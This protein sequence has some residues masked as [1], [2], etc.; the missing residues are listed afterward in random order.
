MRSVYP[1]PIV[2]AVLDGLHALDVLE[3]IDY[4]PESIQR[5]AP[6]RI[7]CFCPVHRETEF[8]SLEVDEAAKSFRCVEPGCA[9]HEGGDLIQL[10]A[11]ARGIDYDQALRVL[12][13][14]FV[15][16]V[17]LP[18]DAEEL[19]R[20]LDEA[21]SYL[22]KLEAGAE[23]PDGLGE[24]VLALLGGALERQRSHRR[25][26]RLRLR[27][28]RARG[29]D[30]QPVPW[31][32][33]LAKAEEEA[34]QAQA[35]E[36]LLRDALEESPVDPA[37]LRALGDLLVARDAL[38]E[39]VELFMMLADASEVAGDYQAAIEAYR[40]IQALGDTGIDVEPLVTQL[41]LASGRA[42]E[43]A[44]DLLL[45]AAVLQEEGKDEEAA[46]ALVEY[47][48]IRPEGLD[49]V[50]RLAEVELRSGAYAASPDRLLSAVDG[51]IAHR[52]HAGAQGVLDRIAREAGEGGPFLERRVA[53]AKARMDQNAVLTALGKLM[54]HH[55]T[56]GDLRSALAI[57]EA[58]ILPLGPDNR[59]ALRIAAELSRELGDMDA[60]IQRFKR[61]E[62]LYE[63]DGMH[64]RA[65][66]AALETVNL[67]PKVPAHWMRLVQLLVMSGKTQ[68]AATVSREGCTALA[69]AADPEE[70]LEL[71]LFGLDLDAAQPDL[72]LA[73]A[74]A[75]EATGRAKEARGP[76]FKACEQ[77]V[78]AGR[79]DE[80]EEHVRHLLK[81]DPEHG[82]G[83]VLLAG[84]LR[85]QERLDDAAAI[86]RGLA[87][88]FYEES[89]FEECRNILERL[90]DIQPD[91]RQAIDL[92]VEVCSALGDK[93][94]E[95]RGRA[96]LAAHL[97]RA[98]DA[99]GA[100]EQA[101][102]A[103]DLR[104]GY[105]TALRLLAAIHDERGDGPAY[106]AAVLE[107]ARGLRGAG[108]EDE[109]AQLLSDLAARRP[110]CLE[111]RDHLLAA[112]IA[113]G[114]DDAARAQAQALEAAADQFSLHEAA[115]EILGR[116]VEAGGPKKEL[117]K[118][119]KRLGEIASQAD[120][121]TREAL[122]LVRQHEQS[123]DTGQLIESLRALVELKPADEQHRKRLVD[124]LCAQ[125]LPSE[126]AN[127]W[128]RSAGLL[129]AG[130]AAV[131]AERAL[132]EA[133]R[134]DPD[135]RDALRTLMELAEEEGDRDAAA[136][137]RREL[138]FS[139]A[140]S[141]AVDRAEAILRE[142]LAADARD[143]ETQRALVD[144]HLDGPVRD[145]ARAAEAL[146]AL[147]ARYEQDEH[148]EEAIACRR[149]LAQLEGGGPGQRAAL[150]DY[151]V[152]R[153]RRDAAAL[154]LEEM[155]A[156]LRAAGDPSGALQ[157]VERALSI[158][159]GRL[160]ARSLRAELL[161]ESGDPKAAIEEWRA[162]SP[163][164][165]AA[166]QAPAATRLPI[167][168]EYDFE[169]F[170]V[171]ENNRFAW[172]TAQAVANAPGRT[173]HNPLFIHSDVGL[174]KTH[175]L[176]A[177][178]NHVRAANPDARIAYTNAEEFTSELVTAIQKNAVA[179]FRQAY[180]SCD[181]LLLDDV[182]L[183][184]GKQ[185]AQE[186]FF[187]IFNTLYQARRQIVVSSDR[188]PKD[189]ALL[190]QRL[191]SRFGA[192]VLVDIQ[193]PTVEMRM[194][195]LRSLAQHRGIDPPA[196]GL[197][198][199]ASALDQNIR[200]LK[201]GFNQWLLQAEVGGDPPT[202][203]SARRAA[204]MILS[205]TRAAPA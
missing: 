62:V 100:L 56:A 136:Q 42:E 31:V 202:A 87:Q 81:L 173:P 29:A 58:E 198:A 57:L 110:Q 187:A 203:D 149:E 133:L 96:A 169:R 147:A 168:P 24:R 121:K 48:A 33:R 180:K 191:R 76:L 151:L 109:A 88:R 98:G 63:R 199:L 159:A 123:G 5:D 80:A 146:R 140:R 134:L 3:F 2:R 34:G 61:L 142:G 38:D 167:L 175:I 165:R 6:G 124:L 85:R 43:A 119:L 22:L 83:A 7:R 178:A 14:E 105:P 1:E 204:S 35:A 127:E 125:G 49:A 153:G 47:L 41:L 10:A 150:V 55:R 186:E 190:E 50:Q 166:E 120:E 64:E 16:D 67:S 130:G 92:F 118:I 163:L 155:A 27:Y 77:L 95:A 170:I 195:V 28:E 108:K 70:L 158:D 40:R 103:T 128:V 102:L 84:V 79:I 54:N 46:Q 171:S 23:D 129:I 194:A 145:E 176:Q 60:T 106:E 205:A 86:L 71:A 78:Q 20:G 94:K 12:V 179:S 132:R 164:L 69:D 65:A 37:L 26:L 188:P 138:A 17:L 200:E 135:C 30:A 97:R 184:A 162:L 196:D 11:L 160:S 4:H 9:A 59:K 112:A 111:A 141:G 183:L 152:S 66:A 193:R 117:Q 99:D 93:H 139:L 143:Y 122:R 172:A 74:R 115:V 53:L 131:Q 107:L 114:D 192:G 148:D 25:A 177:I 52:A 45:R 174:G 18:E 182:H 104:P 90:I 39:G 21:E 68:E 75:F 189:I 72:Q 156:E 154:E 32:V 73:A 161:E 185:R 157:L 113:A 19:Q 15:L 126:A 144:L 201:A 197:E 91:D 116:A 89:D 137:H 51:L 8:R 181:L 36:K 101:R 44:N 13:D 82:P